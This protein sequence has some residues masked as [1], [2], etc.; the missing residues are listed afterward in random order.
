[1]Q[2]DISPL[3]QQVVGL[4]FACLSEVLRLPLLFSRVGSL[5]RWPKNLVVRAR[6]LRFVCCDWRLERL[7]PQ[8]V[9]SLLKSLVYVVSS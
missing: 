7:V 6:W 4:R 5:Y 9:L 1:M 3:Y 2:A 8:Q